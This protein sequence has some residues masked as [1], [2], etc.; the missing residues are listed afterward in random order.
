M[1]VNR[2]I[3]ASTNIVY[4]NTAIDS[5][6]IVFLS[7][8]TYFGET[9]TVKDSAGKSGPTN[10]I[11]ITT[12][13]DISYLDPTLS[14][15]TIQQRFGYLTFTASSRQEWS[16]ANTFAFDPGFTSSSL[17]TPNLNTI[18]YTDTSVNIC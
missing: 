6:A 5:N 16:L 12:C 9:I 2:R 1:T 15:L 13:N 10:I 4:V 8:S 18:L 7:T 17:D 11:R 3:Q 14:N